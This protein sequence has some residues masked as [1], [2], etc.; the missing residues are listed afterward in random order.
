MAIS[1]HG[2][3]AGGK[4]QA[5]EREYDIF[6][7]INGEPI[8]R[9]SVI[10]LHGAIAKAKDLASSSLNNTVVM[11]MATNEMI[12]QVEPPPAV[13]DTVGTDPDKSAYWKLA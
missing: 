1:Q 7:Q 10:G 8:W 4:A 2:A 11:H 5:V 6:E 9:L 3:E 12:A 13:K